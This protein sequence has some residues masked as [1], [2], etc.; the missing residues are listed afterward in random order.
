M[1]EKITKYSSSRLGTFES[2]K[3]KYDL[4]Y[5][6]GLYA[7]DSQQALVTKKGTAF[8]DF[9]ER[10]TPDWTEEKIE[11]ERL[12]IETKF[13]LPPEFSLK[14]PVKR[15]IEFYNL[16]IQP[17]IDSGGKFHR[18]IA[19]DFSLDGKS[20]TGRLDILLEKA[21]GTFVILDHKTK[22]STSTSYY[23]DQMLL[24]VWALHKQFGI[25][26]NELA[27]RVSISIF[28]PFANPDEPEVSKL[29]KAVKFTDVQ[30][31][32]TREKK[33][34][35]IQIIESGEWEPEP[36]ISKICEFCSFA[37]MK[38]YCK[39]SADVGIVPTRGIIIKTRE[40]AL[41]VEKTI[42]VRRR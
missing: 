2:C 20:F 27:R 14:N 18:E 34:E 6:Q 38:K 15:F 40:W 22:K 1:S 24:Y 35:L 25:P 39:L 9:A 26:E 42:P 41:N 32:Q 23:A 37:G 36:T 28:F 21:D 11:A 29:I 31:N 17:V 19:F 30:L 8:H 4:S 33:K 12:A 5:N 10:Y 7:D 13:S 16:V 3:L